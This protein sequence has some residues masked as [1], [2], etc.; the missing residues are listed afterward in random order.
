M[1]SSVGQELILL[2][3][4]TAVVFDGGGRVL[5]LRRGDNGQWSLP[6]G[7]VD[8]GEQPSD[9]ALREVLEETG[10]VAEILAVA[11]VAT[12]PV[13]YPN[14]DRC[15]YLNIWF[16]CRAVG[17]VLAADGDESLDVGWFALDALPPLDEW[18]QLRLSTAVSG[19]VW[20]QPAGGAVHPALTRPDSL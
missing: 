7:M 3:G 9:A 15:E 4:A 1:R 16:R 12:H 14:G 2:P 17:G 6:A 18:G 19:Q 20:F 5:L 8:P 13:V 11:G 10:I